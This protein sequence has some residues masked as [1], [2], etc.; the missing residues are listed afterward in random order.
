M[1][2]LHLGRSASH[3][4]SNLQASSDAGENG[5]VDAEPRVVVSTTSRALAIERA[6]AHGMPSYHLSRG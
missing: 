4:G 2:R 3:G 1:S 5:T 6:R